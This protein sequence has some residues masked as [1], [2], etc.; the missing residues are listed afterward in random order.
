MDFFLIVFIIKKI[1]KKLEISMINHRISKSV[2]NSD[3][4]DRRVKIII[5]KVFENSLVFSN[6]IIKYVDT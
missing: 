4:R 3:K 5:M 1:N 2:K 6:I